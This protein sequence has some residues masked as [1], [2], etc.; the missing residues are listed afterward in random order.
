M[1]ISEIL[2]GIAL[3]ERAPNGTKFRYG[4]PSVNEF[5]DCVDPHDFNCPGHQNGLEYGFEHPNA[6]ISPSTPPSV[7]NGIEQ[8]R[9]ALRAGIKAIWATRMRNGRFFSDKSSKTHKAS[10]AKQVQ[11]QQPPKPFVDR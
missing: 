3:P 11:P 8:A 1:R 6:P 2:E 5:D 10:P 4:P 7:R 9:N